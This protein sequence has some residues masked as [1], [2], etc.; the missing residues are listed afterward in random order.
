MISL[1]LPVRVR[2]AQCGDGGCRRGLDLFTRW[3]SLQREVR[4]ELLT[5]EFVAG[6]VR[7]K[8]NDVNLVFD[9]RELA[10]EVQAKR[11]FACHF[12]IGGAIRVAGLADTSFPLMSASRVFSFNVDSI[13]LG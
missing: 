13:D 11:S 12:Q 8:L 4:G 10:Y 7:A 2:I 3:I 1:D 6:A 9:R 5:A